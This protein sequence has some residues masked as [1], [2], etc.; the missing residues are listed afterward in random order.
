MTQIYFY[1]SVRISFARPPFFKW[2]VNLFYK[3]GLVEKFVKKMLKL[4]SVIHYDRLE[5]PQK[6]SNKI[7]IFYSF[8]SLGYSS[9]KLK[10]E[11]K[12]YLTVKNI[13]LKK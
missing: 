8:I 1:K 10:K 12:T 4:I 5:E 13:G 6:Q 11:K 9:C 2:I 7:I 3:N